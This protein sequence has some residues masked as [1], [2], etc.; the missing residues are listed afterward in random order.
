MLTTTGVADNNLIQRCLPSPSR[1]ALRPYPVIECFQEIPCNPCSTSCP[2]HAILPMD[3][4]H[5]I[6]VLDFDKCT[7]CGACARVCPGLA[8]FIID[9]SRGDG[10][11]SVSLPYEFCPLPQKGEIVFTMDRAGCVI[12]EGTVVRVSP[13]KTS[14]T[15]LVTLNV[16]IEQ[17]HDV[18]FFCSKERA[19]RFVLPN[20]AETISDKIILSTIDYDSDTVIPAIVEDD[21][22]AGN[23][24]SPPVSKNI[25]NEKNVRERDDN[26]N[27]T[28]EDEA[29]ICR[30]E[31]I[32]RREIRELIAEGY[33]T[34][35]EIK[36][37]S[38]SGMGPCQ[39]R[40]CGPLIA[41]EIARMTGQSR[42]SV[43]P[44]MHRPPVVAQP[45]AFFTGGDDE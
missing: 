2:F 22:S 20:T 8:I 10:T 4:I 15:P 39:A 25:D 3:S 30:C 5:D 37:I 9:E 34:V 33:T 26:G 41:D 31:G 28:D 44:S 32:T 24:E 27:D 7:G 6:P 16:P 13:G 14:G 36:R 1:R 21:I 40:T 43:Q 38:R 29:I 45:I 42:D 17:V 18:R 11:G 23:E 12:G 19:D 35:D